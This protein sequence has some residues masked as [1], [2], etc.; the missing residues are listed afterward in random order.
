MCVSLLK[1]HIWISEQVYCCPKRPALTRHTKVQVSFELFGAL[2]TYTSAL[3]A[4]K[5]PG[6]KSFKY[7]VG[8]LG[9]AMTSWIHSEFNWPL[10]D[11]W[12]PRA[13]KKAT[14]VHNK[15]TGESLSGFWKAISLELESLIR[16]SSSIPHRTYRSTRHKINAIR[17]C[18]LP[19]V[20]S[21]QK[22]RNRGSSKG[23]EA[24][25]VTPAFYWV[26]ERFQSDE[27]MYVE[28][29]AGGMTQKVEQNNDK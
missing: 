5:L 15:L 8:I 7:L 14:R 18:F 2:Y 22:V 21:H 16:R 26:F 1:F 25:A 29:E 17:K 27:F 4:N 11:S 3:P 9:E 6:Q 19:G 13:H 28:D 23:P 20:K 24:H 12:Y 10:K